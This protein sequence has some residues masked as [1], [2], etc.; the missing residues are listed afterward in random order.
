MFCHNPPE[1]RN[2]DNKVYKGFFDKILIK[3]RKIDSTNYRLS[4]K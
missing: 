1:I 3:I 4:K 2:F